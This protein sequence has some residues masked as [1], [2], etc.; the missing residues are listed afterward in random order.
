MLFR[1][2]G[3]TNN[4]VLEIALP[5]NFLKPSDTDVKSDGKKMFVSYLREELN[6]L[7]PDYGRYA[8]MIMSRATFN[9]TI[10]GSSEFGEQYKM[11]LGSN[12]MKLSTGL[13]SSDLASE[14]FTG[15]GLP[16]IEIKEDYVKDQTGKNVQIYADNRITLLP[17]DEIG[18]MRHHTPYEAVDPVQGRTY[19]AADGQMLISNYRDKNGRYMEYTAEWIPQIVNP[20]LITNIDLSQLS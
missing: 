4:K 12:E 16:R 15:L 18:Y 10:L 19:T 17:S 2:S 6:K 5:F 9:K 20:Q 11:I 14:V 8:K 1:S 3:N 13:I 7:A